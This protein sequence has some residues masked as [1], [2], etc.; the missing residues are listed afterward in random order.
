MSDLNLEIQISREVRVS[1]FRQLAVVMFPDHRLGLFRRNLRD[2]SIKRR[3]LDGKN[4][5]DRLSE[6]EL[7]DALALTSCSLMELEDDSDGDEEVDMCA[8]A[9]L[10]LA[11][12]LSVLN[13]PFL[14]APDPIPR[15]HIT[16]DAFSDEKWLRLTGFTGEQLDIIKDCLGVPPILT[17]AE[18]DPT[19][20]R[21]VDG[22]MALLW[23]LSRFRSSYNPLVNHM[24]TWGQDYSSLSKVFKVNVNLKLSLTRSSHRPS[25]NGLTTRTRRGCK[26]WQ[27]PN[28]GSRCLMLPY[29]IHWMRGTGRHQSKR[30]VWL[31]S[32]TRRASVFADRMYEPQFANSLI[33]GLV[34]RVLMRSK[35]FGTIASIPTTLDCRYR[36]QRCAVHQ[37]SND[38]RSD[39][40]VT[41]AFVG[42]DGM[43]YD[44]F[45]DVA[46]RH[47]DQG[48]VFRWQN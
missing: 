21:E 6:R 41:Q 14:S 5:M 43:M 33:L 39:C 24:Q 40:G 19:K 12:E 11:E 48:C 3:H 46:G 29:S 47:N 16:V 34:S 8:L 17:I 18:Q 28:Q 22:E 23:S 4:A 31:V 15:K 9:V 42:M 38:S 7:E 25:L 36:L 20:S 30:T 13:T 1:R 35:G 37:C 10:G 44:V 27:L 32:W 45:V 2:Y 26:G